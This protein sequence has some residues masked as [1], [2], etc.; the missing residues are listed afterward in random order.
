MWKIK[1]P[2]VPKTALEKLKA[3]NKFGEIALVE[4]K[5]FYKFI[6]IK[7]IHIGLS[8]DINISGTKRR[9]QSKPISP[10]LTLHVEISSK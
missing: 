4:L 9:V 1:R 2:R 6:V 10:S 8:T 3:K 7:T 5:T